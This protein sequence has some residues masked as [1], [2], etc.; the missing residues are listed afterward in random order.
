MSRR[1]LLPDRGRHGGGVRRDERRLRA[2]LRREPRRG[3][4]ARTWPT[5]ARKALAGQ[6]IMDMHTHFLRD[7][8]RLEGFVRSREAVGKAGWNPALAGKPQTLDDLKFANYFKEIYFDSDTKVALISRLG[9]RGAA[10]LVPH[11]RDEGRGAREGEP[12]HRLAAHV[13]RT[14]SSCPACRAGW[15]RSTRRSRSSS[16]TRSRATRS[17]TTPTSSSRSTRGAWTTRS[18]LYPFYEKLVEGGARQRLRAQGPVPAVDDAAVPAPRCRTPTCATWARR[19][20]TGRSSTSSSTTRRS[21][22]PAA[23]GHDGL[24]AVRADRPHR[25]GD[26]PRRD[27]REVRRHERLRRPRARSSRR[28]RWPSRACA[29]R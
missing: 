17:A 23:A 20:R 11:Q 8:T 1:A 27:S 14:R 10:R 9:L 5:S 28:A 3:R 18:S 29:R 22:S 21:A 25:L 26:R 24:D 12:A 6:F 4:D 13:R 2:D 15:T 19:R 16:P 7:D